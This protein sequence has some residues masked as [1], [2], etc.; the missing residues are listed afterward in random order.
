MLLLSNAVTSRR[1]KSIL[2]S[3]TTIIILLYPSFLAYNDL[4]AE[5][6]S[7]SFRNNNNGG[8]KYGRGKKDYSNLGSSGGQDSSNPNN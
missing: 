8:P 4:F 5:S 3:R 2:F 7:K 6:L 1:D